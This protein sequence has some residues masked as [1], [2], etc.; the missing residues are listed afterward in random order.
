MA[1]G[2]VAD[3]WGR[4]ADAFTDVLD[5]FGDVG[6]QLCVRRDGELVVD[7]AGGRRSV[8]ISAPCR[9]Q[10]PVRARIGLQGRHGHRPRCGVAAEVSGSCR[11]RRRVVARVRGGRSTRSPSSRCCPTRQGLS[12]SGRRCQ[13]MRAV[14]GQAGDRARGPG[15]VLAAGRTVHSSTRLTWAGSLAKFFVVPLDATFRSSWPR[16]RCSARYRPVDRRP[17]RHRGPTRS[18]WSEPPPP[19]GPDLERVVAALE[20]ARCPLSNDAQRHIHRPG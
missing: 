14:L 20:P 1:E 16:A 2:A 9:A 17:S 15:T 10:G 6:A 5:D 18:G 11:A 4:V 12:P 19:T 3:G 8:E 7:L 13:S